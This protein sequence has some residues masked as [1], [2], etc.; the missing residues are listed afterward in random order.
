MGNNERISIS[1]QTVNGQTSEF[2]E[3]THNKHDNIISIS[4]VEEV[5]DDKNPQGHM[6]SIN[7]PVDMVEALL[8]QIKDKK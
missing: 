4:K 2:L 1:K 7:V 5:N 3:L 6:E 8:M